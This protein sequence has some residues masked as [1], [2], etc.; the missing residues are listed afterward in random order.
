MRILKPARFS[1]ILTFDVTGVYL[2]V[3][4]CV[5]VVIGAAKEFSRETYLF[6]EWDSSILVGG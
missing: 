2:Q 5:G 3:E 4:A 1:R 6:S